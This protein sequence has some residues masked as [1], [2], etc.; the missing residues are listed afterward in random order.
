MCAVVFAAA[1]TSA[2]EFFASDISGA[3][4]T[5]GIATVNENS[6]EIV[7]EWYA[8]KGGIYEVRFA[9]A[10]NIGC[11]ITAYING[12]AAI[13]IGDITKTFELGLKS[14]F[15]QIK[16]DIVKSN[17][18]SAFSVGNISLTYKSDANSDIRIEAN[19]DTYAYCSG[20]FNYKENY[21]SDMSNGDVV[22]MLS[23]ANDEIGFSVYAPI[24]GEY[25]MTAV[26]SRLGQTFTSDINMTVNGFEYPLTAD[27]MTHKADLTNANDKGLMK[28]YRKNNTVVLKQGMNSVVFSGIEK[29]ENYKDMYLYYIDCVDFSFVNESIEIDTNVSAAGEYSYSVTPAYGAEYAAEITMVSNELL[30]NIPD[31]YIKTDTQEYVKLVKGSNVKV[32]SEY[33]ENGHLYGTYRLNSALSVGKKLYLKLESDSCSVEKIVLKPIISGVESIS[34]NEERVILKQGEAFDLSVFATDENGYALNL[35]YLREEGALTFKT[36]DRDML[37][38]DANG[39]VAALKPGKAVVTVSVFDGENTVST[40]VMFNVPDENYSFTILDAEEVGGQVI[41]KIASPFG[42][43]EKKHIMAF[44][45]YSDNYEAFENVSFYDVGA[46]EKGQVVTY[47]TDAND[48]RFKIISLDSLETIKPVYNAVEVNGGK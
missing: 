3:S 2:E 29:R 18:E 12:G 26:L 5:E 33:S 40:D 43:K 28:R 23:S 48:N 46:L 20:G 38:A 47:K 45:E 13:K 37:A 36:S 34:P 11:D 21:G 15:N 4:M 32:V 16:L 6:G 30:Y 44:A 41:V 7:Y 22:L 24:S 27:T 31:C 9:D 17:A 10:V 19:P 25:T 42:T 1:H 35:D 14:G 8:E 39:R